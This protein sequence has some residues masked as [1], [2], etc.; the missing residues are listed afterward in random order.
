ME[1]HH[2]TASPRISCDVRSGHPAPRDGYCT[3]PHLDGCHTHGRT[4][5]ATLRNRGCPVGGSHR[6]AGGRS[7]LGLGKRVFRDPRERGADRAVRFADPADDRCRGPAAV[8]KL[9]KPALRDTPTLDQ[10]GPSLSHRR[11]NLP[12]RLGG[13]TPALAIRPACTDWWPYAWP[14]C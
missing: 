3:R 7:I 13:L 10:G 5:T 1:L 12:R 9:C 4:C 2:D 11:W 6:L 14:V 8:G